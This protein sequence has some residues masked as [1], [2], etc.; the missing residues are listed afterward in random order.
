MNGAD[1]DQRGFD[2]RMHFLALLAGALG[3]HQCLRP[4]I[5]AL[6]PNSGALRLLGADRRQ[7]PARPNCS[8]ICCGN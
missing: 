6:T 3:G 7:S 1:D 8:P 4:L 5:A 2:T